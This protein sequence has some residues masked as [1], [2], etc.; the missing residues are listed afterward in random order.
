[1]LGVRRPSARAAV[2][3][4][5]ATTLLAAGAAAG[6][7]SPAGT[8]VVASGQRPGPAVL[9]APPATAPQLENTGP[10]QADPIL[11]SGA[12][13]YRDGEW[14]YQ[15]FLYDDHGATGPKATND[16]IGARRHLYSPAGGTY[17]YPQDK[18]SA[19]NAA[20][21]V[22]LR[23]KPLAT[24]TAFRI[25]LNTLLDPAR[26][27]ATIAL[28]TGPSAA[29]P[30][31]A[32]VSSPA[33]LFVTWHGSTADIVDA[34][35]GTALTPAPT[36]QVDLT[37]RQIT[38]TVP[39]AAWNP[40][41]DKVRT[42][43]G[44]GLWDKDAGTYL[45]PLPGDATA[46]AAGGGLP[47]GVAIVNVGPRVDEPTPTYAGATM[48][49]TAVLGVV[50]A[51]WWRERK[52]SQQLALG[53]VTPFSVDVDFAKLASR[54]RDDSAVP[55]TGPMNR[56]LA[57]RYTFGQGLDATKICYTLGSFN[58]GAKCV[59]QFVGQLQAYA[60]YV[61]KKPVPAKGFGMTLLLH[62]LSANYNQ[63]TSSKNQSQLGERG[64]GSLVVTPGGRGPDGFYQGYAE[65]DTFETWADVARHYK[66]D[67]DWATVTG[68]SMGGFG[69]YRL[70]ARWPDLFSR[71][72]SV[73]G[74]PGSVDD[75]LVSLRNTPLLA[76]NAA[77]DEL[78]NIATSEQAVE[79]NTA[80]GIRFEE[81]KFLT[82]DHLT[83]AANDEFTPGATFLG[84]ARVDHNPYHVTYVVDPTEDNAGA[85]TV[86]NHA[87]WLSDL[88]SAKA[89]TATVD[90]VSAA[91]GTTD[92]KVLPLETTAGVLTGGEI[93]AMAFVA[94][95]QQWGPF[96][97]AAPTNSAKLTVTNLRSMT[98]QLDR[99]RLTATKKLTLDVTADAASTVVLRGP[100]PTNVRATR[101]GT[102][103]ALTR[104]GTTLTLPV[105]SGHHV[106]V[107]SAAGATAPG[108][109]AAP[110]QLPRTGGSTVPA[111][112]GVLLLVLAG[113]L[114]RARRA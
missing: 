34:V 101:D 7:S 28:G 108:V 35:T 25:T 61:P 69:T 54:V 79:D 15:D 113:C 67:A 106:Y 105:A 59:G 84:S 110:E 93:P 2:A 23:V 99:A 70:L 37:R 63:Y 46:T 98:V 83:L 48:G 32:G 102:P 97:T 14:V 1:M 42:S 94:R 27:A 64:A 52:Q 62:S 4:A 50:Y 74:E 29:W 65:A 53:D 104:S 45:K 100:S 39:H 16:P 88:R 73:V 55:K 75:Q 22:E 33:K 43:V 80:A 89:G 44:V 109:V 8:P 20:D 103:T 85:T 17:T 114:V 10:W 60:L 107:L 78:V 19:N 111:V 58:A 112:I 31:G 56:I 72:W 40:K 5:A 71:G 57:S 76:W 9:Y 95:S 47:S 96:G 81:D 91:F 41:T 6:V 82:A 13:S 12:H 77:G 11:I 36:A 87:Y 21:L 49:D 18:V 30:H 26:S 68:Y 24:A 51:P 90:A 86:A 38:V 92:A 66:V 3:L